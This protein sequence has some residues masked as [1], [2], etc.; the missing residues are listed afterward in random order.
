MIGVV[1]LTFILTE[2]F[3]SF[4]NKIEV[5]SKVYFSAIGVKLTEKDTQRFFMSII[6]AILSLIIFHYLK[7]IND[8]KEVEILGMKLIVGKEVVKIIFYIIIGF[9][10]SKVI[11]YAQDKLKRKIGVEDKD[12]GTQGVG[13]E[14]P[15]TDDETP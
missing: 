14:I 11:K 8:F 9:A 2:I 10:P 12:F 3:N 15:P 7:P 4:S 6:I 5:G 13:G 1:T